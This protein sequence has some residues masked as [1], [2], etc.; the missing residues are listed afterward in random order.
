M[1]VAGQIDVLPAQWRQMGQIARCWMI[2]LLFE[3][4]DGSLQVRC[5]P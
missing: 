4:I 3:V 5:V 1:V 2:T